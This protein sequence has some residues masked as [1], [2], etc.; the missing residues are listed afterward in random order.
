[1]NE[2]G[3]FLHGLTWLSTQPGACIVVVPHGTAH[4]FY[5]GN[6]LQAFIL[7]YVDHVC[8]MVLGGL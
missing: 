4:M 7:Q 5:E 1:M 3:I 2:L 8:T 6:A